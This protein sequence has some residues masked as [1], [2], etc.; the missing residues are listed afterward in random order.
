MK[1]NNLI[2]FL[3]ILL[4]TIAVS[5]FPFSRF[6]NGVWL[7]IS[8]ILGQVFLFVFKTI[9]VC[10][11]TNLNRKT[12]KINLRNTL[13]LI[14]TLLVCFS[15]Y[16][17]LLVLNSNVSFNFSRNIIFEI[18]LALLVAINEEI[19]FRLFLINNIE[20]K[21][22]VF[23]VI[24]SSLVF[25]LTHL[26]LFFSSFNVGDLLVVA[27]TLPLGALLAISFILTNSIIPGVVIHFLFNTF[28]D[29]IFTCFVTTSSNM[30][31]YI[32]VNVFV[33]VF[34]AIYVL[35]ILLI[36][37]SKTKLRK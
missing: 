4:V 21:S 19:V 31:A 29:T 27:Y 37:F 6:L 30:L 32:L 7:Y 26:T 34:I 17:Y 28:N 22:N 10:K 9:F 23:K 20:N 18:I 16:F 11:K 33:A 13:L 3:I 35:I 8:L 24:I 25:A 1:K 14:P 2:D 15:N 5:S 36:K 12:D